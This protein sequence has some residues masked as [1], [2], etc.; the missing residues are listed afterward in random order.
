MAAFGGLLCSLLR[1]GSKGLGRCGGTG[2][3]VLVWGSGG[4]EVMEE[5]FGVS[6]VR[7]GGWLWVVWM[8]ENEVNLNWS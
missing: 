1:Q 6:W 2:F 4:L 8:M 5:G 3:H 7:E